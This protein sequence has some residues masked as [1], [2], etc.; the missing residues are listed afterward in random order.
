DPWEVLFERARRERDPGASDLVPYW[1]YPIEGG[2]RIE[3]HVPA[4]PMSRDLER[5]ESLRRLL[6]VYR[7]AFGQSRQDDLIAF[8]LSRMQL[9]QARA[10]ADELRIDL[11]PPG[12]VPGL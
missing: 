2:A 6:A 12:P 3:R 8:L 5:Y 11:T 1:V 9:E 10:L 7:M 4:L